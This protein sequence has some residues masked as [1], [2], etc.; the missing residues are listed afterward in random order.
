MSGL[1]FIEKMTK[2]AKKKDKKMNIFILLIKFKKKS[3]SL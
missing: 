2:L 1:I 3:K